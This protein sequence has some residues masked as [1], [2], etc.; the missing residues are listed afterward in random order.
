MLDGRKCLLSELLYIWIVAARRVFLMGVDL[1]LGVG[2]IEVISGGA[3]E[4]VDKLLN[5]KL[6][7]WVRLVSPKRATSGDAIRSSEPGSNP[8]YNVNEQAAYQL[9]VS[10]RRV[11]RLQ[12]TAPGETKLSHDWEIGASWMDSNLPGPTV[13]PQLNLVTAIFGHHANSL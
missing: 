9:D 1:L 7:F 12:E 10:L 3:I 13:T 6:D 4:I 11:P 8:I 2:F 5:A